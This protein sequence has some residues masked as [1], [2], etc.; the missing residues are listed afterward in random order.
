ML[1]PFLTDFLNNDPNWRAFIYS[2]VFTGSFGGLLILGNRPNK[3]I[4][5][6]VRQAFMLTS[7]SW[8]VTCAASALPFIFSR[9]T[10]TVT[11]SFFEA[12]SGLTTTGATVIVGLDYASSGILI[13]RSIIQWLGGVGIIVM[14]LTILPM[15]SIGGMQLFRSEFSDR[16]EKMLPRISQVAAAI[17]RI[18]SFFTL[19]CMIL[20]W[21]F[22]MTPLEAFCH[23][24]TILSTG[25]FST[26]DKSI[27]AFDSVAIEII[28]GIFMMIG[29]MTMIQFW[30]VTKGQYG[31][32]FKDSQIRFYSGVIFFTTLIITLWRWWFDAEPLLGSLRESSF[33]VISIIT[34]SGFSSTDFTYWTPFPLMM[35]FM[36]LFVGGCTGSTAG[37]IKIFRFQII[38]TLVKT[39]ISGLRH[40]HG[41]FIPLYKNHP[42]AD[43]VFN[44]VFT[45]FALFGSTIFLLTLILSAH[46][47]DFMTSLS[48]AISAISNVGPGVSKLIGPAGSF[49]QL[50]DSAKWFLMIGM[51]LGRLEFM[52]LILIVT[53]V[54]WKN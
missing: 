35:I 47:L 20:L 40:P 22:G 49:A 11:D 37:G 29:G 18:Y 23:A 31:I 26:A 19:V 10:D 25:G 21:I 3:K 4:E 1:V 12:V 39:Q 28:A 32:L 24:L 17:F 16:S 43:G 6:S 7:F 9:S 13:W 14:G 50:P 5:L 45:F 30:S 33:N 52:T 53:P 2:A 8:F 54:Y 15:L 38:Y 36:L 46:D 34:T 42:V 51:L 44:S 41:I 27:A 48:G